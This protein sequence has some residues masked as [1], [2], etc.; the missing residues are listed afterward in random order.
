MIRRLLSVVLELQDSTDA[1]MCIGECP[2]YPD[3][4]AF[5]GPTQSSLSPAIITLP[6]FIHVGLLYGCWFHS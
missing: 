2:K 4:L 1:S 5:S 6:I 3:L